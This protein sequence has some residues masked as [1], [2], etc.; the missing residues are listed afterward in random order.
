[1]SRP[2]SL[3]PSRR[4]RSRARGA[5]ASPE[6]NAAVLIR[7]ASQ[8]DAGEIARLSELDESVLPHGEQLLGLLEGRV[9]AALDVASGSAI[10]DPFAPTV[11]VV[12]LLELRAAQMRS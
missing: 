6:T 7:P 2:R 9:V 8:A 3:S 4:R 1:M 5:H 11:G 12:K 10:A